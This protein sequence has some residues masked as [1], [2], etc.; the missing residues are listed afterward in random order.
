MLWLHVMNWVSYIQGQFKLFR[1]N[2]TMETS[3]YILVLHM[4]LPEQFDKAQTST[5]CK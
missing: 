1:L 3:K 4:G 5:N 2:K